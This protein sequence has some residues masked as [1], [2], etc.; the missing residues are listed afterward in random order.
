MNRL[1]LIIVIF[2]FVILG[3]ATVYL[4]VSTVHYIYLTNKLTY[5]YENIYREYLRYRLEL[6][7]CKSPNN[8]IEYLEKTQEDTSNLTKPSYKK[9]SKHTHPFPP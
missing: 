1:C 5:E 7:R 6:A 4:K 2:L 9:E 8:L 3:I